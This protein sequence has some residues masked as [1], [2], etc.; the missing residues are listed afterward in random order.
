MADVQIS[1]RLRSVKEN[2][3]W[4][5]QEMADKIGM[6][7]RTLESYMR[8]QN[9][10]LPGLEAL[11]QIAQGLEI[12]LDWLV[13]GKVAAEDAARLTR[14]ASRA[15]FVEAF[16]YLLQRFQEEG[17]TIFSKTMVLGLTSEEWAAA[18]SWE[19]G[20]RAEALSA[21]GVR[22]HTLVV[23]EKTF[24]HRIQ[25]LSEA[26]RESE[27]ETKRRARD[28]STRDRSVE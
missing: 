27:R 4:T 21:F 26:R 14:L 15:S 12:S 16:D 18:V 13:L 17:P 7:R 8:R 9:A 19:A 1:D 25:E 24:E 22:R 28:L 11:R 2:N 6:S 23:A 3:G 20:Q 10:A 5:A